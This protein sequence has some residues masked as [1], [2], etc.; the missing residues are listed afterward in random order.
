MGC[1]VEPCD[2]CSCKLQLLKIKYSTWWPWQIGCMTWYFSR[3][4]ITTANVISVTAIV[5]DIVFSR[6][7]ITFFTKWI[8]MTYV[9]VR[10]LGAYKR[11]IYHVEIVIFE[12]VVSLI[13][14][15]LRVSGYFFVISTLSRCAK[16][17]GS[18]DKPPLN[19]SHWHT[20]R[21]LLKRNYPYMPQI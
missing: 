17:N 19:L 5:S 14:L 9:S 3:C 2:S 6:L 11:I 1:D 20:Y 8:V 13:G 7:C 15:L 18:L 12:R 10:M 21:Y 4:S 16:F